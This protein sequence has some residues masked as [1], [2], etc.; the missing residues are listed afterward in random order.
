MPIK[1]IKVGNDVWIGEG[2]MIMGGVTVGD[3]INCCIKVCSN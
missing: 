3:G 2:A 1:K